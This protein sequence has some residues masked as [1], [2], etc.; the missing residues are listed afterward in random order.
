M[1]T[2]EFIPCTLAKLEELQTVSI[3]TFKAAFESQNNPD[4]FR[5]YMQQAFSL[6]TLNREIQNPE[7]H[8]FFVMHQDEVKAYFKINTGLGQS[9]P[10]SPDAAELERF[11]VLPEHIGSGVG[12]QIMEYILGLVQSWH[13]QY[14]WLG[15]WEKNDKA[16][17]FY[18]RHGFVKF[19]EHPY[20]VGNDCQTDWM[21]RND[22][23][24]AKEI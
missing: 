6:E 2:L 15:V 13:K 12:S 23:N 16:I 19:G 22:L 18:R 5:L 17:R 9:E 14:L 3:K 11:Y 10:E 7:M 20:Y 21:M 8:F 24:R 4:D 1:T